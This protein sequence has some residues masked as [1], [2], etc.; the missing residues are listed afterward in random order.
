LAETSKPAPAA[1][2][3]SGEAAI[4][5]ASPRATLPVAITV[6]PV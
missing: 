5:P 6:S 1:M 4:V 2:L 3:T